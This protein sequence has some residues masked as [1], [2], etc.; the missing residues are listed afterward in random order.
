MTAIDLPYNWHPRRYQR[1]LWKYLH[2]G[3]KRA[4]SIWHRR[5][6]KDEVCLH[7]AACAAF[8]RP[9]TYWHMLPEYAQ[10]RKAIW[11]AINPHTGMRRID[12]AFPE[13]IR[14][15]SNE[16]EMFIRFKNGA[17]WQVVGSD[18]YNSTVG[19]PPA[20]ITFSEW[21]LA[22][23][24][25]WAYLAPILMENNGWANF[26]TTSRGR[27][28]AK[29]MLDM[30][31]KEPDWFAEV[32]TV[33]DTGAVDLGLIEKQRREYH[34]IFGEEAGDALI[35]QEYFC[36][37]EAAILGAY[38][39]KEMSRCEREG[40]ICDVP[41]DPTRPVHVGW[42][43]GVHDDMVLWFFQVYADRLHVIDHYSNTGYSVAHYAEVKEQRAKA[44]GYVYGDD[45]VP[46]DAKVRDM[47][48]L[49]GADKLARQRIAVMIA[50]GLKPKVVPAHKVEDGRS[51]VRVTLP[52]CWFDKT[53]CSS[54]LDS[55]REYQREW[56]EKNRVFHDHHKHNWAC[57][58]ADGFR[59]LAMAWKFEIV[60]PTIVTP[61]PV[62]SIASGNYTMNEL[63]ALKT[64]HRD[65]V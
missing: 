27:N 9:A 29:T 13:A 38:Y 26:I 40:R 24:A 15:T 30:A 25:S 61:P 57:H 19:S 5:S 46:P 1:K 63:W 35:E 50:C 62:K 42:D 28:H 2:R 44:L 55:L 23:P 3:G 6:G 36:S 37:F 52:V 59:Y 21:A 18:R 11:A 53:R 22:N 41:H 32:L 4:I 54:G 14:E 8:E 56:D 7:W 49:G 65:R 47:S 10:G 43:L 17:T 48:D 39:G 58:D 33:N 34:G 20:G 45:W 60:K 16:Q 12:E 31:R 51:A 64:P